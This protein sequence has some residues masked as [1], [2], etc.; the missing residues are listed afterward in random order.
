MRSNPAYLFETLWEDL[1]NHPVGV[2]W[3]ETVIPDL[4]SDPQTRAQR[5]SHLNILLHRAFRLRVWRTYLSL[6]IFT[7]IGKNLAALNDSGFTSRTAK[8]DL[9]KSKNGGKLIWEINFLIRNTMLWHLRT[10]LY[11]ALAAS[12]RLSYLFTLEFVR[13]AFPSV[14][15]VLREMI[16]IYI[17]RIIRYQPLT[18]NK[19]KIYLPS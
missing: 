3:M 5:L 13:V 14:A 11:R 8:A 15:P 18:R 16:T 9:M 12:P 17:F 2:I 7:F 1:A 10:L 19:A 6:S 4:P